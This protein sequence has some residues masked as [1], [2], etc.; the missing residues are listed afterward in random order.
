MYTNI[1]SA[2]TKGMTII[3]VLVAAA[4]ML[5][6]FS[7]IVGLFRT[8][9]ELVGNNK[10]KIGALAL[11]E[12]RMELIHSLAYDDV[13][14]QGG[15]PAG[16]IPQNESLTLNGI[17]YNRRVLVQYVDAPEDGLAGADT[18]SIT[19]DYKRAK[20]EVTWSFKGL[21]KS[22]YL[23][24]NITPP[25]LETTVGGGTLI[26][27]AFDALGAPVSGANVYIANAT[28]SPTISLNVTTDATG[29]ASF[30]GAPAASEYEVTVSKSGY[31]TAKTYGPTAGNPN[32]TPTHLTVLAGQSTVGSFAIDLLS[33]KTVHTYHALADK[34]WQDELNTSTNVT[35]SAS[36]TVSGGSLILEW[37]GAAYAPTGSA[38]VSPG[39]LSYLYSWQEAR[40]VDTTPANTSISYQIYYDNVGTPT[41]V[42]DADL[43]GNSTGFTTS[44]VDISGLSTATYGTL[45]IHPILSTT[46]TSVTPSVDSVSLA[47]IEGPVPFGSVLFNMHG[48]KTIGSD[49][50]S[51]PIYKYNNDLTTDGTGALFINNLE[52]DNYLITVDRNT[53]GYDISESCEPQP[54]SLAPNTHVDT[55][56]Y[57]SPKT[58]NSLLVDVRNSSAT[59]ISNAY[60]ELERASTGFSQLKRTSACGQ[61]F[62]DSLSV[63]KVSTS[64]AYTIHASPDGLSTTTVTGVDVENAS[65]ASVTL[66]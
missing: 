34:V 29:Q 13:G 47:Y 12:E 57:L 37:G 39:A 66:N 27:K 58:S 33:S 22:V 19:T 21:S 41:I 53:L 48:A 43:P 51:N 61:V 40:W 60:V 55:D 9:L 32:P 46:D 49:S 2:N 25:G 24:S 16:N 18:N 11:A 6:A 15:I 62:F 56:L 64:N 14:T 36:T 31:S 5:I 50:S 63:G 1:P 3:E 8:G 52:W 23:V 7:G 65:T 17:S 4:I 10:A 59:L 20:V 35:G 30:P 44:P 45:Y 42:P 26:V 54:R 28:T 38:F